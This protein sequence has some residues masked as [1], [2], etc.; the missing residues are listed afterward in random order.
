MTALLTEKQ[1]YLDHFARLEKWFGENNPPW[2]L[3]IRK[4]AI[5]RFVQVAFPTIRQEE[6]KYTNVAPLAQIPFVPAALKDDDEVYPTELLHR[7]G[8]PLSRKVPIDNCCQILVNGDAARNRLGWDSPGGPIVVTNLEFILEFLLD[9]DPKWLRPEWVEPYLTRFARY[10]DNPFVA[11]NTALF[12]DGAFVHVPD[13][14]IVSRPIYLVSVMTPGEEPT[15][16]HPRNLIVVGRNSQ[17]TIVE[18]YVGEEDRVYFTNA[19]TEVVLGENAKVEHYRLQRES[20]EAYHIATQQV[21]QGRGSNYVSHSFA[22]GGTLARTDLNVMHGGEGCETTLNGLYLAA[23][24]Q[25]IDNHTRIDHA[26]PHCTSHELYKGILGGHG[27]GVF[28]GKIFVHQDAQKTDARQTS[29]TLLLSRDAVI[30]AKPQ[31]EI[32]AD[33]VKCTHGASIGQLDEEQIFYLQTR[34]I[35]RGAARRL[36]TFAFANEVLDRMKIDSLRELLAESLAPV[37]EAP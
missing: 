25:L 24:E 32:H 11:L 10:Q 18:S 31:L 23:G 36:L 22:E 27:R 9:P 12:R 21:H 8:F 28:N 7:A 26:K 20:T 13:E 1:H 2:L 6:W 29:K 35:D 3:A 5:E 37:E 16:T 4:A 17:A 14:T 19:V 15:V 33:D 30:D 34:G